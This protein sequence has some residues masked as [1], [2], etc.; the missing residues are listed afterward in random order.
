[1]AA[2]D[3]K[4]RLYGEHRAPVQ[5]NAG[6]RGLVNQ[7]GEM[8]RPLI[9]KYKIKNVV[10][11]SAGPLDPIR[12]LL[13]NP[14]NLKTHGEEWGVVPLVREVQ[15]KLKLPVVLENDAAAAV[16]AEHWLGA[17]RKTDDLVV[18]TL[19]TGLGVGVFTNGQLVRSGR[20]LHPEAGH[21]TID[22]KD[23]EWLC[24]CGNFGCAEA[25]LSGVNFTKKM[26]EVLERP[27]LSGETLVQLARQGDHKAIL[28]FEKYGKRLAAFIYSLSV[29]F[30]PKKVV[31]SGGFSHSADL[32]LP[33]CE[34]ELTQLMRTRRKGCDLLPKV[35][36]SPFRDEA[37]L[38]GA[39]YVAF[40]KKVSNPKL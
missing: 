33:S 29:I 3:E 28:E 26:A 4:G 15:K 27:G 37:G 19:G 39:A 32:F 18:V 11:A 13:L 36:I 7:F 22:Y 34:Q 21:I 12:G 1:M 23:R 10:I 25:F 40:S 24:G 17:G 14:T 6:F 5:L 8:G 20:H 30:S 35:L 9:Q 31:L 2:V 38:L 16:L